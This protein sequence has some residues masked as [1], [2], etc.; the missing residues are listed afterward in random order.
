MPPERDKNKKDISQYKEKSP[1]FVNFFKDKEKLYF[2]YKKTERIVSAVHLITNLFN[3]KEPL[4]NSLREKVLCLLSDVLSLQNAD[5]KKVSAGC[6][7]ITSL[8][9]VAHDSGFI[10]DMNYSIIKGE[11][12]NLGTHIEEFQVKTSEEIY[13]NRNFFKV[14]ALLNPEKTEGGGF[15][16]D[17]TMSYK[18]HENVL[19][20]VPHQ[21]IPIRKETVDNLK[22]NKNHRRQKILDIVAKKGKCNIKDFSYV[23]TD[24]SEKTIQRELGA[25]VSEGVLVKMGEKRWST[26]SLKSA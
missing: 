22:D 24:Y 4:R 3:E 19:Y 9:S 5:A 13:F 25:M 26:Y 8:L 7:E 1:V 16:K 14:G 6:V 20:T 11:I 23:I 2:I 17:K 12:E 10:T 21:V 18:G 15:I